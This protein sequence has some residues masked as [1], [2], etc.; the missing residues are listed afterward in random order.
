MHSI[1][2]YKSKGQNWNE[3]TKSNGRN[4]YDMKKKRRLELHDYLPIILSVSICKHI[5][6]LIKE[7]VFTYRDG[8]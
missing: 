1:V 8:V 6:S 4:W 5:F 7:K 3:M 2:S